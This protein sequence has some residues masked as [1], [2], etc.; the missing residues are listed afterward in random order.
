[1]PSNPHVMPNGTKYT[2]VAAQTD[3]ISKIRIVNELVTPLTSRVIIVKGKQ[4]IVLNRKWKILHFLVYFS[5]FDSFYI[6]LF[7]ALINITI[8]KVNKESWLKN[9]CLAQSGLRILRKKM[10]NGSL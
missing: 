5:Y 6:R 4:E 8:W 2:H 10:D 7:I 3:D 9:M 1:M